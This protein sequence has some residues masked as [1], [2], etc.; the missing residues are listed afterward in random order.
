[1][2]ECD[3]AEDRFFVKLDK[4]LSEDFVR[5]YYAD[6]CSLYKNKMVKVQ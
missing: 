4:I 3:P 2:G 6:S 5:V 1:M